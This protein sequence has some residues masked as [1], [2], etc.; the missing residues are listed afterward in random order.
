MWE[1]RGGGDAGIGRGKRFCLRMYEV[2][3]EL[4]RLIRKC[5]CQLS[6]LHGS[7]NCNGGGGS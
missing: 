7:T 6:F 4:A 2:G 3:S 1:L 5:C